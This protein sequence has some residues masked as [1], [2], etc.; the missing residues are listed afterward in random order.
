MGKVKPSDTLVLVECT[1]AGTSAPITAS[2]PKRQVWNMK[3]FLS[4]KHLQLQVVVRAPNC[5][6]RGWW[7]DSTNPASFTPL[8]ICL[9]EETVKAIRPFYLLSMPG[10]LKDPTQ[11][12]N[13]WSCFLVGCVRGA[14]QAVWMSVMSQLMSQL[15][16]YRGPKQNMDG[17][18]QLQ[19][20]QELTNCVD[21]LDD[22]LEFIGADIWAVGE[23]KVHHE[24]LAVEVLVRDSLACVINQLPRTPNSCLSQRRRPLLLLL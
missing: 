2:M 19:E 6:S 4:R 9:L 13:V 23:A 3:H 1:T 22:L 15:M 12:V 16:P 11:G 17:W 20:T 24:P 5:R 14:E 18:I 10:E 7:F 21:D 8:C